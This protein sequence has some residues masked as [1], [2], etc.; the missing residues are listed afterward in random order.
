MPNAKQLLVSGWLALCA[1]MK[2]TVA[3]MCCKQTYRVE[4]QTKDAL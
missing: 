2:H 1:K 3:H 4:K